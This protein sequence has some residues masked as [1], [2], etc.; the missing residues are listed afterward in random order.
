MPGDEEQ[1]AHRQTVLLRQG[2]SGAD[3]DANRSARLH[4]DPVI[5]RNQCHKGQGVCAAEGTSA[6]TRE[7]PVSH[8]TNSGAQGPA[9][10]MSVSPRDPRF[11]PVSLRCLLPC[12]RLVG[13]VSPPV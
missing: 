11:S 12:R 9:L 10:G 4:S 5:R 8:G 7:K 3:P 2:F 6:A 13:L 1:P